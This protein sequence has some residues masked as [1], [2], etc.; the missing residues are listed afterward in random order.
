LLRCLGRE[1]LH[2]IQSD[3][4]CMLF[5]FV[6]VLGGVTALAV[7]S[8]GLVSGHAPPFFHSAIWFC[9]DNDGPPVSTH[10]HCCDRLYCFGWESVPVVSC[11]PGCWVFVLVTTPPSLKL[12]ERPCGYRGIFKN[13]VS[14]IPGGSPN[15][16]LS[17][18]PSHFL[19]PGP[20]CCHQLLKK[21]AF[22]LKSVLNAWW[23]HAASL[24]V[25]GSPK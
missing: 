25:A 23:L 10:S 18:A 19:F 20:S 1:L 16:G 17:V 14:P 9:W 11:N 15:L 24:H 12:S 3:W 22:N 8:F 6:H 5:V 21:V 2:S 13:C 4:C 7:N